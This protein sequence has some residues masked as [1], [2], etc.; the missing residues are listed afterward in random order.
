L[1]LAGEEGTPLLASYTDKRR[2]QRLHELAIDMSGL[3]TL[4]LEFDL[5]DQNPSNYLFEIAN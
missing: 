4:H 2:Q 5:G 1:L 3:V